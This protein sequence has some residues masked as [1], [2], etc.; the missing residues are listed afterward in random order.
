MRLGL[1]GESQE[2]RFGR[3]KVP[4]PRSFEMNAHWG[5]VSEETHIRI[6]D[7]LLSSSSHAPPCGGRYAIDLDCCRNTKESD[8]I[9]HSNGVFGTSSVKV[10]AD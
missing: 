2:A 5:R 1:K 3:L 8:A 4:R 6:F 7:T 9:G 10:D